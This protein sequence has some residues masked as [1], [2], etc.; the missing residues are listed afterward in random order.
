MSQLTV[1]KIIFSSSTRCP[2]LQEAPGTETGISTD[3]Q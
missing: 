3:K 2:D 1:W